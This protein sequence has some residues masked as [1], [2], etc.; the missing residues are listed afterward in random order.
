MGR[1]P[2]ERTEEEVSLVK[3]SLIMPIV[4]DV[5]THDIRVLQS[6]R[7]KMNAVYVKHLRG[8]QDRVS[9]ELYHIR[10]EL[11]KRGIKVFRQERAKRGLEAEYL[12]RGYEHQFTM[13]WS[14]VKAEVEVALDALMQA[15]KNNKPA[16]EQ[17]RAHGREQ[18]GAHGREPA[19]RQGQASDREQDR[20]LGGTS[21]RKS[22]CD[23]G[24]QP[25]PAHV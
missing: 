18:A 17:G 11:R 20:I 4:L 3:Q 6:S 16:Q 13:M 5:L 15:G 25:H 12:C 9:L 8:L 21:D 2:M 23:Q 14:V 22:D 10:R 1:A 19:R 24:K 7:A